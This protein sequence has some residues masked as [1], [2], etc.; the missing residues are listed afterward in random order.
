ML[1]HRLRR[2]PTLN[3]RWVNVS[4]LLGC[5]ALGYVAHDKTKSNIYLVYMHN[6]IDFF[7]GKMIYI[8]VLA[9]IQRNVNKTDLFVYTLF[10]K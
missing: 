1:V 4:C 9:P 5:Y 10:T 7:Y 6:F 2:G 8:D 3:Q